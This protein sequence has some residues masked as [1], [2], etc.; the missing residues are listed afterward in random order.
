MVSLKI[1]SRVNIHCKKR[2]Y[3]KILLTAPLMCEISYS[4]IYKLLLFGISASKGI[5][6]RKINKKTYFLPEIF[7]ML[8]NS[9][10][11]LVTLQCQL[12]KWYQGR[13]SPC[14]T[15]VG[16]L[17]WKKEQGG[18]MEKGQRRRRTLVIEKRCQLWDYN[19]EC[20]YIEW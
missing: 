19:Y 8:R 14:C 5:V 1:C 4:R 20:Y 15:V 3:S 16:N 9:V 7:R 2:K 11:P 12:W 10:E 13:L 18:Q 17:S 6:N